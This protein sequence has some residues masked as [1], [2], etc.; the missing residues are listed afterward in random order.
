MTGSTLS[1]PADSAKKKHWYSS[2][3]KSKS[4]KKVESPTTESPDHHDTNGF[5]DDY[6]DVHKEIYHSEPRPGG[7]GSPTKQVKSK[8]TP[9]PVDTPD[10]VDGSNGHGHN[11]HVQN[12]DGGR[13]RLE[14]ASAPLAGHE[15]SN[16]DS[17][18]PSPAGDRRNGTPGAETQGHSLFSFLNGSPTTKEPKNDA[19]NDKVRHQITRLC[20]FYF[21]IIIL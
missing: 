11:N 14:S 19:A 21:S 5:T 7:G 17:G 2:I 3:G 18:E 9:S 1:L 16:L 13:P 8:F 15:T 20:P 12:G 6:H 4:K 10:A